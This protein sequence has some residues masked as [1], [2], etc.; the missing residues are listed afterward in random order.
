MATPETMV[1]VIDD[2]PSF[3]RSTAALIGSEGFNVQTFSSPEE[4]LRSR[5]PD[6]PAR[7]DQSLIESL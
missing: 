6:V 4:F 5:R 3:R 7:L 2:D 1:F